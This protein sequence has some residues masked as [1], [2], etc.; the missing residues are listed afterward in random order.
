LVVLIIVRC[1][2]SNIRVQVGF[3]DINA[4]SLFAIGLFVEGVATISLDLRDQERKVVCHEL[5]RSEDFG[6]C[7]VE[8]VVL[9]P[10]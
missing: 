4:I 7:A 9:G 2:F 3:V 6:C 5:I 10:R 1:Y 8:V